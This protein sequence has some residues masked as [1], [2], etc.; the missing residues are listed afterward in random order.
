MFA[1]AQNTDDP[2]VQGGRQALIQAV[3]GAYPAQAY[4]MAGQ[5]YLDVGDVQMAITCL[6]I[7]DAIDPENYDGLLLL[8]NAYELD[9]QD[10]QAEAVYLKARAGGQPLRSEGLHGSSAC[11]WSR[12]AAEAADMMLLAYENTDRENFRQQREDFLPAM[13]EVSLTA[14]RYEISA[15]EQ[16]ISLTSPQGYDVYYT[17][18]DDAVL[19]EDGILCEDGSII[20]KEGAVTLRAVAVSGDLVSDPISVSYTFYYPHAARAQMQSGAQYL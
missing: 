16:D 1:L 8:A 3:G 9:A 2:L 15:M 13:P 12:T 19:P 18:D 17:V 11:T 5:D 4:R 14:G 10:D 6:R 7:S 20:P